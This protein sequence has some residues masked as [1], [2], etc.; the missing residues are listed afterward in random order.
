VE[1]LQAIKQKNFSKLWGA[2]VL[3]QVAANLLNFALIIIVYNLSQGTRFSS[4]AVSLLVLSFAIPSIF[5]APAAGTYVDYWDRNKI[6]FVSNFLRAILAFSYIW[7]DH[8]LIMILVLTFLTATIT[9]FFLPA[10]AATIPKVVE[11]K[12]LLNA[13]ALFI[14]T[15]YGAFVVAFSA[16]GPV[17]D[18]L[19]RQGP[20]ILAGAM[21]VLS[22]ILVAFLPK[23]P[24]EKK[25]GKPPKLHLLK[26][27]QHNWQIIRE[28]PDRYFSLIQLALTQGI[29]FVLI[30]LAP[31]LSQA[32][33]HIPLQNASHILIIP[34]GVGMVLGVLMVDSVSRRINKLRVIQVCLVIAGVGLT[35]LGL[36]GL[37]YRT[38]EGNQIASVATIG[39]IVSV[40]MLVLG[41][42]N[43]MMSAAAQTLLQETTTDENRG[44]VFG[45]L[46]M[47]IN[48]ASVLPILISG[49]LADAISV[50]KVLDILGICLTLYA[51]Y[52]WWKHKPQSDIA[53][54]LP[55]Q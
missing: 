11:S 43:A 37:L 30:T 46:Q 33:L 24:I 21:F 49:F 18:I 53:Q 54:K 5:A 17:I 31:A 2:Q 42:V 23:L 52:V 34:V 14:F 8:S 20:Y 51:V 41:V 55:A 36:A 38:D 1:Y 15:M 39:L 35:S 10:E 28:H 22:T 6:L 9:Q 16:S 7:L 19:G 3:S 25:A 32:L 27:L 50:T 48:A 4:F 44:K 29:V 40:I 26:Q 47:L 13:N 45:S 12:Y